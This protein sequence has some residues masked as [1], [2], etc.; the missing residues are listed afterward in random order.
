[1]YGGKM[2][3]VAG[4]S[5]ATPSMFQL[6]SAFLCVFG[7]SSMCVLMLRWRYFSAPPH[8]L[9]TLCSHGCVAFAAM[10][11]LLNEN[12]LK[13]FLPTLG[14]INPFLYVTPASTPT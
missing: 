10:I 8:N 11:S 5:A 4:T 2:I 14:H 9:T 6:A 7:P 1:M 3:P 13:N 12:R